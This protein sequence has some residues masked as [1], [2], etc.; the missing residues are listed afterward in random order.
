MEASLPA[1][2][3]AAP[4]PEPTRGP[5]EPV[6]P[7][8]VEAARGYLARLI[9]APYDGIRVVSV[10]A[11]DWPDSC[12]GIDSPGTAC[13]EVITSGYKVVLVYTGKD[14]IIRTDQSGE[15]VVLASPSLFEKDAVALTW[16]GDLGQGCL[17]ARFTEMGVSLES[18]EQRDERKFTP[19][20]D[21][22]RANQLLDLQMRWTAIKA[23]TTSGSIEL[24]GMGVLT[25]DPVQ[26]RAVA[27]WARQ[28]VLEVVNP[29]LAQG[30][31]VWYS[32]Q[33]EGGIIG[34]CESLRVAPGGLVEVETCRQTA[35]IDQTFRWLNALELR[36]VYGWMAEYGPGT[37][38]TADKAVADGLVLRMAFNGRGSLTPVEQLWEE[39]RLLAQKQHALVMNPVAE[40]RAA[41][42]QIKLQEYLQNLESGHYPAVVDLYAGD[43]E[44]LRGWNPD[45]P[46]DD[47]PGL[48]AAG[49]QYNGLVCTLSLLYVVE[50][51]RSEANG[52]VFVVELA[53]QD[54]S[55]FRLGPCCGAEP[56]EMP[57]VNQ[58]VFEL[59][60]RESGW[61]VVSLP[62]YIP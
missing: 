62:V 19:Y 4:V 23:Q 28:A 8:A 31:A 54:G 20:P 36:Q 14:Y 43:Y 15:Q 44:I 42:A 29:E 5:D 37:L 48:F 30:Q 24:S 57:P 25:A 50:V 1:D 12:L 51:S 13:A 27:D 34:Y 9:E 60:E 39:L 2:T 61:R 6:W 3:P 22:R 52:L 7:A 11:V 38:E 21:A 18:C 55:L 26:Q 59:V 16:I 45:L 58:F 33:L 17:R 41:A 49:C 40:S 53:D 46:P 35:P 47:L 10:D 56:E 32:W